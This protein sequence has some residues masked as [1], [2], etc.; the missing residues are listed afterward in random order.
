MLDYLNLAQILSKVFCL[1][2]N[3]SKNHL[4]PIFASLIKKSESDMHKNWKMTEDLP[5]QKGILLFLL[6]F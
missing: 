1:P 3:L 4:C 6:I 5:S 2:N